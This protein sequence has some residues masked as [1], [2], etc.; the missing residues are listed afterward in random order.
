MESLTPRAYALSPQVPQQRKVIGGGHHVGELERDGERG[1]ERRALNKRKETE[2]TELSTI[3]H[4]LCSS[5]S[6]T[7]SV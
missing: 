7:I 1:E 4:L 2:K 5:R 3:S 6:M